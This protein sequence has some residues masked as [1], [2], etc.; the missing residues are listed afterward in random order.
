MSL[1]T[2]R[3][4]GGRRRVVIPETVDHTRPGRL[5]VRQPVIGIMDR[6]LI[7]FDKIGRKDRQ[8]GATGVTQRR[9]QDAA[10]SGGDDHVRELP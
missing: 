1:G 7:A 2:K 9:K 10:K 6:D 5:V 4:D 8:V 3:R